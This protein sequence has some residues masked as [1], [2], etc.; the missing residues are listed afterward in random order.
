M[1]V[2]YNDPDLLQATGNAAQRWTLLTSF[3]ISDLTFLSKPICNCNKPRRNQSP[4]AHNKCRSL[5]QCIF[6]RQQL[7][8]QFFSRPVRAFHPWSSPQDIQPSHEG[9]A[10]PGCRCFL[11]ESSFDCRGLSTE[12]TKGQSLFS[13]LAFMT[14]SNDANTVFG[15]LVNLSTVGGFIG[16]A[17]MN[18]TYLCFC[19]SV[20][21]FQ[22][23]SIHTFL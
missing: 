17:V 14:V 7:F 10:S 5:H 23:R 4:S 18:C 13:L 16:W 20:H 6:R 1:I 12:Q 8:V 2:P 3:S 21:F 22:E 11:C 9:R 15:W 19:K